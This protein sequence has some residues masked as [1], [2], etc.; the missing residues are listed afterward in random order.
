MNT[1]Y[2]RLF[3]SDMNKS[4]ISSLSWCL[5][6]APSLVA[7]SFVAKSSCNIRVSPSIAMVRD[8]WFVIRGWW[9]VKRVVR[10]E[11]RA[12][13]EDHGSAVIVNHEKRG[14]RAQK[15]LEKSSFRRGI[16]PTEVAR[17]KPFTTVGRQEASRRRGPAENYGPSAT[18]MYSAPG[19]LGEEV[20]GQGSGSQNYGSGST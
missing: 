6:Q 15:L 1:V 4:D 3:P 19:K 13:G 10:P 5:L 7:F 17:G 20:R 8:S 9:L 18:G 16:D 14:K 2:D 11:H 12:A